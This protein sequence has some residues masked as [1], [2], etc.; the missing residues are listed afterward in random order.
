MSRF[1]SPRNEFPGE[2]KRD[3]WR[4]SYKP[5]FWRPITSLIDIVNLLP[6]DRGAITYTLDR[7]WPDLCLVCAA[8]N[9]VTLTVILPDCQL[10]MANTGKYESDFCITYNVLKYL[11]RTITAS[12]FSLKSIMDRPKASEKRDN[13]KIRPRHLQCTW[14]FYVRHTAHAHA[15]NY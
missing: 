2:W 10:H 11:Q 3:I 13:S 5:M 8:C 14:P 15:Y 1:H 6:S 4:E 12:V 9:L 7:G